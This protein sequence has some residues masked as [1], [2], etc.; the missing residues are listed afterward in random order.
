MML[1]SFIIVNVIICVGGSSSHPPGHLQPLGLHL[2]PITDIPVLNKFPSSVEFYEKYVKD[3]G[4][5]VIFKNVL[6][7][8]DMPVYYKWTDD[9]LDKNYGDIMVDMEI[10]KKEIRKGEMF[11]RKLSYF[12][13]RYK[14]MDAYL[15]EDL[16]DRMKKDMAIPSSL[17]CGGFQN[18]IH[19]VVMW[20]SSGGTKS[21]FHTDDLDNINCLLD[22][23][24]DL[25]MMD[26]KYAHLVEADGW[27]KDGSYSDLDVDSVDMYK[28]PNLKDIPWYQVNLTK[29][30]CLYIPYK[31]YHHVYSH[32]GRNFAVNVWF[33][34][35]RW[36]NVT[37]CHGVDLNVST[38]IPFTQFKKPSKLEKFRDDL[39]MS[40]DGKEFISQTL[41]SETLQEN[42]NDLASVADEIFTIIDT[43][44]DGYISISELYSSGNEIFAFEL[45]EDSKTKDGRV[46]YDQ[47]N[48]EDDSLKDDLT[49]T[50][51]DV[52]VNSNNHEEL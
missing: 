21:V 4:K 7:T 44:K 11:S 24:K 20:F 2:P 10:G 48:M 35:R 19:T 33:F 46:D 16:P 14:N 42:D 5:P 12:L 41:F 40:L 30:D 45:E 47:S 8:V 31:W 18:V 9:Y 52:Y 22:G 50:N 17:R 36:F 13:K 26:R 39:I 43:D 25:I 28:F 38:A 37:D 29:G 3:G 6:E 15:V 23:K 1:Y 27:H 34:H 32:P 51:A 49:K